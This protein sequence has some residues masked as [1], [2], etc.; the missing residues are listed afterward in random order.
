MAELR[1][2]VKELFAEYNANKSNYN[3]YST[4]EITASHLNNFRTHLPTTKGVVLKIE[5]R[6]GNSG[7]KYKCCW[8]DF[9]DDG[10]GNE[11][12]DKQVWINSEALFKELEKIADSD[13]NI[14]TQGGSLFYEKAE[15]PAQ[16]TDKGNG[17]SEE[18]KAEAQEPAEHTD[19]P[20]TAEVVF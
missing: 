7:T 9:I 16:E 6:T 19:E 8:V 3:E 18:M 13:R 5:E 17:H 12:P 20:E 1:S 2:G 4:N 11:A 14:V 10:Y 15:T